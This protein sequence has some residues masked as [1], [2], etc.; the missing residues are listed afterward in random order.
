MAVRPT[1]SYAIDDELLDANGI[2]LIAQLAD[3]L[4]GG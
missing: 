4:L 3:V 2:G 1:I